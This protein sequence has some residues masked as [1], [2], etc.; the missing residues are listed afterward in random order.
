MS[1]TDH[2]TMAGTNEALQTAQELGVFAFPGVEISAEVT[3]ENLHILGYFPPGF[4]SEQLEVQLG[5]IRVARYARGKE[6]L[7]KLVCDQQSSALVMRSITSTGTNGD[8][9]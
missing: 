7:Y 9:H 4:K 5:K 2:D 3:N 6:I 1:L 8:Q